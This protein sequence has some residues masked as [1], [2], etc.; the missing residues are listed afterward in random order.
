MRPI[1]RNLVVIGGSAGALTPLKRILGDLPEGIP[2]AILVVLHIPSDAPPGLVSSMVQGSPLPSDL[3]EDGQRL[4]EGR[5][6]IAPPD[7]HLMVRRGYRNVIGGPREN[8]S[9]PAIDPTFRTAAKSYDG[10]TIAVLL[11]GELNDGSYGAMVVKAEG[12]KL[13]VQD[14]GEAESPS[15]PRCALSYATADLVIPVAKIGPVLMQFVQSWHGASEPSRP[16]SQLEADEMERVSELHELPKG[17][18]MQISCPECG[19]PLTQNGVGSLLH[20]RCH[21]GDAFTGEVLLTEQ[22]DALENALWSAVRALDEHATL[23]RKM[24]GQASHS[25]A[26]AIGAAHL[27]QATETEEKAELIRRHFLLQAGAS[28][29]G[30]YPPVC[31]VTHFTA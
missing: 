27:E 13:V 1:C 29:R 9:R 18:V 12:G 2:A 26:T 25:G 20:S 30:T 24:G 16:A 17:E 23:L 14:P 4:E 15:M 8:R 21:T 11:S 7:H 28:M 19:G 3:A 22:K 10:R 31:S 5:I 6:F